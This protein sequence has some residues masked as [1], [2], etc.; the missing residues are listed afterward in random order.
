MKVPLWSYNDIATAP[1]IAETRK[2]CKQWAF[3]DQR[4]DNAIISKR[5]CGASEESD[6]A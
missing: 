6:F 4:A 1:V 3:F 5:Y 2:R